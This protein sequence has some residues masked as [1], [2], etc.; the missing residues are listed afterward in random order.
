MALE[1]LSG[2]QPESHTFRVTVE[3]LAPNSTEVESKFGEVFTE[4]YPV[5]SEM[6]VK[7]ISDRVENTIRSYRGLTP[8]N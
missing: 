5:I 7:R 8:K 3:R 2:R 4:N 1:S 6:F